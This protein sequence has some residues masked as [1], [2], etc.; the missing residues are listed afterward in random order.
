MMQDDIS[1]ITATQ[2]QQ[3]TCMIVSPST[4]VDI[5]RNIAMIFSNDAAIN[6]DST[7]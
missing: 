4:E 3:H 1:H 7:F 5:S 2:Q 6:S